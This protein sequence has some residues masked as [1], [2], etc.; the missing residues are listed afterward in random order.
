MLVAA[1]AALVLIGV[2]TRPGR[3]GGRATVEQLP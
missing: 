2:R 3:D 1:L